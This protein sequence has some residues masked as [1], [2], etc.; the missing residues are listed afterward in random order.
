[1]TESTKEQQEQTLKIFSLA[2]KG[3]IV[4]FVAL[5]T[6]FY[7]EVIPSVNNK[8]IAFVLLGVAFMDVFLLRFKTAKMRREIDGSKTIG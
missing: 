2:M 5:A 4:L 8:L 7:F 1:M 3:A 6:L